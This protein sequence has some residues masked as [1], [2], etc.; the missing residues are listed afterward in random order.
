MKKEIFWDLFNDTFIPV[1]L[2]QFDISK[3]TDDSYVEILETNDKMQSM[4]GSTA[5]RLQVSDFWPSLMEAGSVE[6]KLIASINDFVCAAD[7]KKIKFRVNRSKDKSESILIRLEDDI[8]GLVIITSD[9]NVHDNDELKVYLDLNIE[10]ACIIEKNLH[11]RDCNK[12]FIQ[13]FSLNDKTPESIHDLGIAD[14]QLELIENQI[15]KQSGKDTLVIEFAFENDSE[16]NRFLELKFFSDNQSTIMVVSDITVQ[17]TTEANLLKQATTD[18]LTHLPNRGAFFESIEK[19]ISQAETLGKNLIL[20]MLDI[21]HFK[22]INDMWGHPV[23]DLVLEQLASILLSHKKPG[24]SFA[25]VGGEEFVILIES[26]LENALKDIGTIKTDIDTFYFNTVGHVSCSFG[27]AERL[28]KETVKNF[29]NR[30][31]EA[32]YQA[33]RTG[34]NRIIVAKSEM[35]IFT[36]KYL[37]WSPNWNSGNPIIDAE[38]QELLE[39][40]KRLIFSL[41]P[42]LEDNAYHEIDSLI[43]H[44]IQ[45]FASE[46]AILEKIGFPQLKEHKQIH[47]DLITKARKL[48]KAFYEKKLDE[49]TIFTFLIDDLLKGHIILE[50]SKYFA[51]IS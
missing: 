43:K 7:S 29:Y 22:L 11:I 24:L 5:E 37:D 35:S 46:E 49:K 20:S 51:Y 48:E 1:A 41:Y 13:M 6:D 47:A 27:V 45:H 42:S 17:K 36:S 4:I 14:D 34:R 23:G 25:R 19:K 3:N 31:D 8:F 15:K 12:K 9:V 40:G 21:D 50:D 18:S 10:A 16:E 33:K 30:A 28:E 39:A 2:L 32:M 26:D 38:H 44:T